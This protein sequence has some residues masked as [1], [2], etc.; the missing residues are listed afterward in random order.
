MRS[1]LPDFSSQCCIWLHLKS[2][3]RWSPPV[4]VGGPCDAMRSW[5]GMTITLPGHP[6]SVTQHYFNQE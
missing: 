1:N 2:H 5:I 4:L 6:L 3:Q